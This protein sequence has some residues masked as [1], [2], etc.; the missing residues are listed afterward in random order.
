MPKGAE[1]LKEELEDAEYKLEH[2]ESLRR[3]PSH[4]KHGWKLSSK[5]D[6]E[7]RIAKLKKALEKAKQGGTRRR[8]R[9]ARKTRGR[10]RE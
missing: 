1:K 9:G 8:R 4:P 10:R 2:H 7:A 6:L 5:S 3:T